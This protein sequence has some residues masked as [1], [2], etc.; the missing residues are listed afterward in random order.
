M[1]MQVDDVTTSQPCMLPLF[2]QAG[3]KKNSATLADDFTS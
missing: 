2:G 3:I 1:W